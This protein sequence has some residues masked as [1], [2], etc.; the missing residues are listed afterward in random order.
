M[1]RCRKESHRKTVTN[2]KS[3]ERKT[4]QKNLRVFYIHVE[5]SHNVY[6][7]KGF[8]SV[9]LNVSGVFSVYL[10]VS[11]FFSVYLTVS[12]FFSVYLNVSG[13]ENE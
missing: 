10:N 9:Y 5:K 8:F 12:G 3:Q 7:G 13:R 4:Q 1:N 6:I 2:I 11:G